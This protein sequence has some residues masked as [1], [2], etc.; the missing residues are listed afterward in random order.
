MAEDVL[1]DGER[2]GVDL[3]FGYDAIREILAA[4]ADS[5]DEVTE[6]RFVEWDL[7]PSNA[8]V[9]DG[10]IVCVI[11]HER[12]FWGDPLMEAGFCGAELPAISD[13]EAFGRGWGRGPLTATER[14]RRRLYGLYLLLV[15]VIETDYRGHTDTKQYD[16]ARGQ[17]EG[18]MARF[19]S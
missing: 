2:R 16:W 15:M 12:A 14:R 7:W 6:P 1:A 19:D 17:L 3:G 11:D 9:R 4:H 5:L 8:M 18:L 13:A 10:R